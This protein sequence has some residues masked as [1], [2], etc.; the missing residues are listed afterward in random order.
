MGME[1]VTR[2]GLG[3]GNTPKKYPAKITITIIPKYNIPIINNYL[4]NVKYLSP[5]RRN[6]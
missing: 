4:H 1:M 2:A 3:G 6:A 5:C